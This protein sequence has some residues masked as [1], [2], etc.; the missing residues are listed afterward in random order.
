MLSPAGLRLS[1]HARKPLPVF[2]GHVER[3]PSETLYVET[4]FAIRTPSMGGVTV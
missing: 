3:A 4:V 1:E 2:G